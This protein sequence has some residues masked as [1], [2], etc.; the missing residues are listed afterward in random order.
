MV[1][2]FNGTGPLFRTRPENDG[3]QALEGGGELCSAVASWPRAMSGGRRNEQGLAQE[4]SVA[5]SRFHSC[6]SSS[7]RCLLRC[8]CTRNS[9]SARYSSGLIPFASQV[10]TRA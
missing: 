9:T 1:L 4:E 3:G 2:Y 5:R 7:S 8:V 6:G 10:A